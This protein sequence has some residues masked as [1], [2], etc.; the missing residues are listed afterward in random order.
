VGLVQPGASTTSA[1]AMLTIG[2]DV[3]NYYRIYVEA[4]SLI[5][6]K[7]ING[8]KATLFTNPYD[9]VNHR[10]LRIR[11]EAATGK[12]VFETAADS[13]GLPGAWNERYR[14]SWNAAV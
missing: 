14:E 7:R 6:Q 8:A 5:I 4:G 10:Y 9:P 12:V 1:D 13:G 11:H 3:S 2:V